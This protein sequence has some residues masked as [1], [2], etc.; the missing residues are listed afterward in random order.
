[1]PPNNRASNRGCSFAFLVKRTSITAVSLGGTKYGPTEYRAAAQAAREG[2]DIDF[3]GASGPTDFDA[4]GSL[5]E[6]YLYGPAVDFLL[7]RMGP[8]GR[9]GPEIDWYLTDQLG[10]ARQVVDK[11]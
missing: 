5:T 10:S 11:T 8:N 1:M 9:Y 3:E 7:A 6:R 2:R 4:N